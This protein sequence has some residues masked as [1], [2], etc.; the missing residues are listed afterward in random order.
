MGAEVISICDEDET[1]RR[2]GLQDGTADVIDLS[3]EDSNNSVQK[4][5]HAKGD[6][7]EWSCPRCTLFNANSRSRCEACHFS[8]DLNFASGETR[9]PDQTRSERLVHDPFL[10]EYDA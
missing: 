7:D 5:A 6:D 1:T 2:S 10:E 8:R 3:K 9:P 4:D